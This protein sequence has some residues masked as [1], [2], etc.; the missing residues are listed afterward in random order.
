MALACCPIPKVHRLSCAENWDYLM[1]FDEIVIMLTRCCR[2]CCTPRKA[3][4]LPVTAVATLPM[5]DARRWWRYGPIIE[6]MFSKATSTDGIISAGEPLHCSR[7]A[8]MPALQPTGRHPT[9]NRGP[10]DLC[11]IGTGQGKSTF[12]KE[13]IHHLLMN[14]QKVGVLARRSQ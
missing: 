4:L 5:K 11:G 14:D 6:A 2:S 10:N 13:L 7:Q 12:T 8:A 3:E 1:Q 9:R